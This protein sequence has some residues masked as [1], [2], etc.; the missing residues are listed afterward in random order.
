MDILAWFATLTIWKG[1]VMRSTSLN[2]KD[3]RD[4]LILLLEVQLSALE[5]QKSGAFTTTADI[6]L[7]ERRW[8][9]IC[10]LYIEICARHAAAA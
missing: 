7:Y 1:C 4:E 2:P 5:K 8:E 3:S 6:L 10:E 9:R